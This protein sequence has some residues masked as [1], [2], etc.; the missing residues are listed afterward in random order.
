MKEVKLIFPDNLSMADFVL[1]EKVNNAEA[2]SQE[3]ILTAEMPHEK[4]V[5]AE[6]LYGAILKKM[7]PKN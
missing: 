2:N 6:T 5:V 3:Q 4:V 7:V 1:K